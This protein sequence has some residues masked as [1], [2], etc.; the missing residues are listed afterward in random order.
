MYKFKYFL[1]GIFF[2]F[3]VGQWSY[4]QTNSYGTKF[5]LWPNSA[6]IQVFNL[7]TGATVLVYL[8]YD[9]LK[10]YL[11]SYEMEHRGADPLLSE[12]KGPNDFIKIRNFIDINTVELIE[13]HGHPRFGSIDEN[14]INR[15]IFGEMT[16][17]TKYR[18]RLR[19]PKELD[20]YLINVLLHRLF[21]NPDTYKNAKDV[22][23][24]HS[25]KRFLR[26]RPT[27]LF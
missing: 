21:H 24:A 22:T 2:S 27:D 11:G 6:Q 25:C 12:I 26:K 14:F 20:V 7:Q 4:A 1:L 16:E 17:N 23:R 13:L 10:Q 8:S 3:F 15:S 18:L 9:P 5:W 19:T